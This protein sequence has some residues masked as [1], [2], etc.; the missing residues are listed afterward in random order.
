MLDLSDVVSLSAPY[1]RP[2]I[3]NSQEWILVTEMNRPRQYPCRPPQGSGKQ[4]GE[5]PGQ[6]AVSI[7][8]PSALLGDGFR[9]LPHR[10]RAVRYRHSGSVGRERENPPQ[11]EVME[12]T[13]AR[14]EA[15]TLL[16]CHPSLLKQII[17]KTDLDDGVIIILFV[18][19]YASELG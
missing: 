17:V 7:L 4:G 16:L 9:A 2:T 12:R 10:H 11:E 3:S 1:R 5:D 8:M 19:I 14:R 6:L 13:G 18:P 15:T